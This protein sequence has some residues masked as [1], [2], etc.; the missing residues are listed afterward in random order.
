MQ[1]S[2]LHRKALAPRSVLLLAAVTA[3]LVFPA[4]AL[5]GGF[6]AHLYAPNNTHRPK[7]GN[8]RIKVTATRGTQKLSGSVHYRFFFQ[9][10]YIRSEPAGSFKHGVFYNTLTWPKDAIGRTITLQVVVSTHYGT[11]YLNWWIKVRA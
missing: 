7:V 6:T 3:A 5:A 8:W 9:G 11:D 2:R 1:P 4:N 10:M